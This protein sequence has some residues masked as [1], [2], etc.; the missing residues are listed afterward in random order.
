M[1]YFLLIVSLSFQVEPAMGYNYIV[2][3]T[4]INHPACGV[5]LRNMN[6]VSVLN[7]SSA[8]SF[9]QSCARIF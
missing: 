8:K 9:L 7:F 6:T 1:V 4:E 3:E 5:R 2:V